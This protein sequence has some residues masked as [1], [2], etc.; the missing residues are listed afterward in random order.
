MSTRHTSTH[1]ERPQFRHLGGGQL[2]PWVKE[3]HFLRFLFFLF[4]QTRK[5]L[6]ITPGRI[7]SDPI[8]PSRRGSSVALGQGITLFAFFR[9]FSRDGEH[10]YS[11][12][13]QAYWLTPFG[14]LGGGQMWPCFTLSH[15]LGARPGAPPAALPRDANPELRPDCTHGKDCTGL[16]T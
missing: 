13:Q 15:F 6:L 16:E 8:S 2:W 4:A 11:C 7:Q 1:T 10:L 5:C 14:R 9:L 12:W 3:S